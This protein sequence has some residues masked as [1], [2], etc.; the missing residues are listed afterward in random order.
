MHT[1][2]MHGMI[3]ID[4]DDLHAVR[5]GNPASVAAAGLMASAFGWGVRFGYMTVG[6]WLVGH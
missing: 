3:E 6:P 5:G 1:L 4:G 2:A